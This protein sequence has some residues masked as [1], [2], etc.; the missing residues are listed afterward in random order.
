M[1]TKTSAS[2]LW[3]DYNRSL[4]ALYVKYRTLKEISDKTYDR[5][6][7][8]LSPVYEEAKK[9]AQVQ[10]RIAKANLERKI[11]ESGLGSSGEALKRSLLQDAALQQ[12]LTDISLQKASETAKLKEEKQAA[13]QKLNTEQEEA[14][15]KYTYQMNEAYR[16]EARHEE[17]L[18]LA[19]EKLRLQEEADAFDRAMREEELALKKEQQAF[20]QRTQQALTDAKVASLSASG[21]KTPSQNKDG[22]NSTENTPSSP[23]VP[24][25]K[26]ILGIAGSNITGGGNDGNDF[27][28]ESI[29]AKAL[30]ENVVSRYTTTDAKG[31][32]RYDKDTIGAS[33][34][35]VLNNASLDRAWRY[36]VYLYA[37]TLGF[38]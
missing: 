18:R 21:N 31:Q 6:I 13:A 1:T 30:V 38:V 25:T 34:R 11:A 9:E 8:S 22:Q 17:E 2:A 19:A 37:K 3:E 4:D 5:A 24:D 29:T 26:Y 33:I 28:P 32:K 27:S 23:S 35:S 14:V 12:N 20:E 15:A 16:E 36:E 10:N 7:S